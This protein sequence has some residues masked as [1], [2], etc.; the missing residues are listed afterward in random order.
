M[1]R[2]TVFLPPPP[3]KF[4]L[5]LFSEGAWALHNLFNGACANYP[6]SARL[7]P[8]SRVRVERTGK[9][10]ELQVIRNTPNPAAWEQ[11]GYT[12]AI[13]V[14]VDTA[15]AEPRTTAATRPGDGRHQGD[16]TDTGWDAVRKREFLEVV[17]DTQAWDP[18][19]ADPD[20]FVATH[21]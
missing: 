17:G 18:S 20:H 7:A 4:V 6:A 14:I 19:S 10:D 3:A 16:G 11:S 13:T 5:R 21:Q 9:D 8:L 15:G 12:A 2:R 1:L